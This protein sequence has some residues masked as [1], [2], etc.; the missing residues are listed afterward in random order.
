LE[1]I[2]LINDI[3][4]VGNRIIHVIPIIHH[5]QYTQKIVAK[6]KKRHTPKNIKG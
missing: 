1:L 5:T 4:N 3:Q 2:L 6:S